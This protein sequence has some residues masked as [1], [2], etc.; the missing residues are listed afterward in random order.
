MEELEEVSL[1]KRVPLTDLELS[2]LQEE[3]EVTLRS[4]EVEVEVEKSPSMS[5]RTLTP[6]K[7][8][9]PEGREELEVVELIMELR[10]EME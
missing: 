9:L 1:F 8:S 3:N 4:H 2:L 5:S 6:D 7:N 10:E